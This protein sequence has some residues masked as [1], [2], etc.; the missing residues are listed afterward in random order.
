L[1]R[2]AVCVTRSPAQSHGSRLIKFAL[3]RCA[4]LRLY[5]F[6]A[7]M[8]PRAFYEKHG[9]AAV[10]PPTTDNEEGAPALL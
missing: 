6:E 2:A 5:T 8:A 9:F 7:N 10:G 3:K 1:D 4:D